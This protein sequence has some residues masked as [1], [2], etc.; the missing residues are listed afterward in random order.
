MKDSS[1]VVSRLKLASVV[2]VFALAGGRGAYGVTI[3]QWCAQF[4]ASEIQSVNEKFVKASSQPSNKISSSVIK[5]I[6]D[7]G[8][9]CDDWCQASL[10]AGVPISGGG[11]GS[12]IPSAGGSAVGASQPPGTPPVGSGASIG[13]PGTIW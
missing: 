1:S 7:F 9:V 10:V 3:P 12:P 4:C 11:S 5:R 2:A 8:K 13:H 6:V